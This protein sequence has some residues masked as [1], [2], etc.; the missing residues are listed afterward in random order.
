MPEASLFLLGSAAVFGGVR[1]IEQRRAV[2][3]RLALARVAGGFL[4]GVTIASPLLLPFRQY[5]ALSF[6]AHKVSSGQGSQADASWGLLNWVAPFFHGV[7]KA[8]TSPGVRE[9]CGGAVAVAALV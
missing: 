5:E 7:K 8:F 2:P 3:V 6:N 9:W 4:L 1:I